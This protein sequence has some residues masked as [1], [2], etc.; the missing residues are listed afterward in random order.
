MFKNENF[1]RTS[2]EF[3]DCKLAFLHALFLRYLNILHHFLSKKDGHFLNTLVL[4]HYY[5]ISI[6]ST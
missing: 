5:N 1:L 2:T 6:I 3:L 4:T